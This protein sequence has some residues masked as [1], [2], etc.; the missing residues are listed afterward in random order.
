MPPLPAHGRLGYLARDLGT[1]PGRRIL[2]C[3]TGTSTRGSPCSSPPCPRRANCIWHRRA[4]RLPE[5]CPRRVAPQ[6]AGR[7]QGV[8]AAA[9]VTGRPERR[10]CARPSRRAPI[11]RD[12]LPTQRLG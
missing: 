8:S 4:M 1:H 2:M 10:E 9:G 6:G 3:A 11:T 5:A 12:P 7:C